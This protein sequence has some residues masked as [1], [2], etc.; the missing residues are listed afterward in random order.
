M[1][2]L[3]TLVGAG[4]AFCTTVS[5]IP[6]LRKCWQTRETGDLSLKM[7]LLL[8]IGLGLWLLYGSMRAD[9]VIITANA[10]SLALLGGIIFFKI[11]GA[12]GINEP[13]NPT[14]HSRVRS[15]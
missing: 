6:Q 5:Y 1:T 11:R 15:S 4:A 3:E 7:L 9:G 14:A 12:R 13:A 10:V 8:A 2:H